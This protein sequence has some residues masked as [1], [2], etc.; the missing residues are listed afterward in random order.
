MK[1]ALKLCGDELLSVIPASIAEKK[2]FLPPREVYE[3]AHFPG[4][5]EEARKAREQLAYEELILLGIGMKL[6]SSG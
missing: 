1:T 3:K 2:G 4:S 6:Y 5:I